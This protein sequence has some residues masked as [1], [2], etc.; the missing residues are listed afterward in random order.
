MNIRPSQLKGSKPNKAILSSFS[1]KEPYARSTG[2]HLDRSRAG[3]GARRKPAEMGKS[4]FKEKWPYMLCWHERPA[5]SLD[6]LKQK[7]DDDHE[8][9]L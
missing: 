8:G 2:R 6:T 3:P 4:D 7:D 5:D 9:I 1:W